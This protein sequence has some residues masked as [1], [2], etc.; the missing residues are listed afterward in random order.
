ML[1]LVALALKFW[2]LAGNAVFYR[3][4]VFLI[5]FHRADVQNIITILRKDLNQITTDTFDHCG[6]F[7]I[8]DLPNLDILSPTANNAEFFV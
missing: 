5:H 7:P 3:E 6:E 4:A 1:G 2:I 8:V